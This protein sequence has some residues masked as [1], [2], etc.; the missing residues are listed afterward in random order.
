MREAKPARRHCFAARQ[1]TKYEHES[2]YMLKNVELVSEMYLR[3]PRELRNRVYTFCVQGSYDN[4]V[5]VRRAMANK[6]SFSL[7]I[8][9]ATGA[10]SYQ[11][12]EDPIASYL[13]EKQV[14]L[15]VA[16]EMLES[17]YWTK[18]FKF[19]HHELRL[20]G[21]FL[22]TDKFGLGMIPANYV[23]RIRL[24]VQP[25]AIALLHGPETR[26]V[27]QQ[28]C[29][30]AMEALA[31]I[32]TARTEVD[33]E[34]D[35]AHDSLDDVNY[36]RSSDDAIHFLLKTVQDLN[37]SKDRGLHMKTTFNSTWI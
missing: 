30:K 27:E 17:Y 8:R 5:I 9:E 4:E 34:V 2:I 33:V 6:K 37:R 13:N 32:H 7:L 16:R 18:T 28:R 3:L 20:L 25:F 10:H 31:A 11:W 19:S 24:Q 36:K 15:D 21:T 1:A 23:R 35:L 26:D 14:G 29:K 12:L 22:E